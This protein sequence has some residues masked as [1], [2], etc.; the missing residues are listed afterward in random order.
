M[1]T[2]Q[3]EHGTRQAGV[4]KRHCLGGEPRRYIITLNAFSRKGLS[5]GE[6]PILPGWV[7]QVVSTWGLD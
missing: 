6:T 7:A 3:D 4:E 1:L 5:T 2:L